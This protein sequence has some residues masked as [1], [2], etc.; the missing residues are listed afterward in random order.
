MDE[1]TRDI[2][3]GPI[4]LLENEI[5]R[6]Q[7]SLAYAIR[8]RDQARNAAEAERAARRMVEADLG[9]WHA[10]VAN[11]V[12]SATTEDRRLLRDTMAEALTYLHPGAML[13]A[14]LDAAR[15]VVEAATLLGS[16]PDSE[17]WT[18]MYA[19]IEAYDAVKKTS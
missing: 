17:T 6:L 18:R 8:E 15:A 16:G 14:E 19:A 10:T 5:R 11:Y 3:G 9:W 1:L 12:T 7:T 2:S 4:P 13:L